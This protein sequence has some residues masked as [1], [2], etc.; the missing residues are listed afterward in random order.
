MDKCQHL[1]AD[2]L[3]YKIAG[4]QSEGEGKQNGNRPVKDS[5]KLKGIGQ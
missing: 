4:K 5:D 3:K 2:N 1:L